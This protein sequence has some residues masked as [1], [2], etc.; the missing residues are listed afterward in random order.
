MVNK[1]NLIEIKPTQLVVDEF[2]VRK[3]EWNPNDDDE[4][5]LVDSIKAQ[6][7]LEPILVRPTKG[8]SVKYPTGKKYSV[9]CGSRRLNA[10]MEARTK[11]IPCVVRE[12][13][14]DVKSL[15]TSIQENLKRR[16][17][18]K[19]QTANGVG[20]MMDMM[21]GG[22]TY[23]Q[24]TAEME[25]IF[26]MKRRNLDRYYNVYKLTKELGKPIRATGDYEV[27]T[28]TLDSIQTA[29]HWD[30]EK[31]EKAINVLSS[32]EK[33]EDRRV[34]VS[35]MK[36]KTKADEDLDVEE[37]FRDFEE[38]QE[39]VKGESYDVYLNA[40]E[41]KATKDAAKSERLEINTL[42]KRNHSNWLKEKG[43]L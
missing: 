10:A 21:N 8:Q 15:G 25:K 7:V 31:K 2:N 1:I 35:E 32:I 36:S 11:T 6:G 27:D 13:L 22:R 23:E 24:K 4:T 29:K 3:G 9:I 41:R 39:Q 18:D 17:M 37:A 34:A 42:I 5:K 16:S 26:G 33:A 38:E 30:K 19:T 20:R 12:D 40:K 14:D 28:H 43:F